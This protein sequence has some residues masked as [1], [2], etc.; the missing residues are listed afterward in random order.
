MPKSTATRFIDSRLTP[1]Q[2]ASGNTATS[3]GVTAHANLTGLTNH[4]HTQYYLI[5]AFVVSG[6]AAA[7][8]SPAVLDTNGHWPVSMMG[9]VSG[10]VTCSDA[11][12]QIANGLVV[13]ITYNAGVKPPTAQSTMVLGSMSGAVYL[14]S[15][16]KEA[17]DVP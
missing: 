14:S 5:T 10:V 6:G 3:S 2:V 1:K 12:L 11:T 8:D 4:D 9:G 17:I 15:V 7:A 16:Y 13:G